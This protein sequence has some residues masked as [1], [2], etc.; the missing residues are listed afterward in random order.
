[1]ADIGS[2]APVSK[3]ANG[4][5]TRPAGARAANEDKLRLFISYSREDAGFADQ[6]DAALDTCGFDCSIDREGISGGE[7][8]KARLTALIGQSD[9]V[10]FVLSPASA[11]SEIC[12]WEVEESALLGKRILPVV[13]RPLEDAKA[14]EKLQALNYVYF[15]PI[16][17]VPGAGFGEGLKLLVAALNTDFDW[18]RA[19]TRYLQ[20][21][22]EWDE[23]GRPASRLLTGS[24]IAEA[25]AWAGQRPKTAPEPTAL[26]L[27]FIRASEEEAERRSNAERQRLEALREA[28]QRQQTA[29]RGRD[30]MQKFLLVAAC[31]AT[32][33]AVAAFVLKHEAD[34]ATIEAQGDRLRAESETIRAKSFLKNAEEIVEQVQSSMDDFSQHKAF[35]LFKS[36]AEAYTEDKKAARYYGE[37]LRNGWGR[38]TDYPQAIAML[39]KAAEEPDGDREAMDNLGA[40]Y[41]SGEG[42]EQGVPQNPAQAIQWYTKAAE[43]GDR[44]AMN[45]LGRLFYNAGGVERDLEAASRW[46]RAAARVP[47]DKPD[48]QSIEARV[49][50]DLS[51][52]VPDALFNLGRVSDDRDR[53][54]DPAAVAEARCWYKMA[55]DAGHAD[56][57]VRLA[58]IYET[59]RGVAP[60]AAKASEW[61][62]KAA[63]SKNKQAMFNLASIFE[64]GRGGVPADSARALMWYARAAGDDETAAFDSYALGSTLKLGALLEKGFSEASNSAAAEAWYERA[65]RMRD[66]GVRARARSLT[67]PPDVGAPKQ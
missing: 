59:G 16:A 64:A 4:G 65:E 2:A 13:C 41:E 24:D 38:K 53:G 42:A 12:A 34:V 30:R 32:V 45:N 66:E 63:N 11:R 5:G 17:T 25:K 15:C 62:E 22:M 8:W 28:V 58:A 44:E 26:Q 27:E 55:A 1:M 20:R 51:G 67:P 48:C 40:I 39:E 52:G 31:V 43:A 54:G 35:D 10:V 61:Y 21:A 23:G 3:D 29:V 50:S 33:L 57:M 7:D 56:A 60:D 46:F 36:A 6:L 9:T 18:M 14:P 47:K 49:D 37:S 19:H